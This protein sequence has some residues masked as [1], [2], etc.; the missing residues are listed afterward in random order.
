MAQD[1]RS[2]LAALKES[3]DLGRITREVDPRFEVA[4]LMRRGAEQ[5]AP[6]LY[7][8]HLRGKS[9]P[10]VANVLA[11]RRRLARALAT[12]AD[13]LGRAYRA[14]LERPIAA[15]RV[16]GWA[17]PMRLASLEQLP[18]ITANE[19]D[20]GPYITAGVVFSEH[21][22]SGRLNLSFQRM[23]PIS[24]DEIAIYV[25]ETSGLAEHG[26]AN[27]GR[28]L[29]V[30]V[31]IGLH[32]AF[33]FVA[34]SWYPPEMDEIAL[35]GGLLGEGVRLTQDRLGR[36][37]VPEAAEIVLEGEIDFARTVPEGPFGEYPG[38]Y[39]AGTLK[40]RP[41]PVLK[42]HR[43]SARGNP[44]YQTVI[45]G[46]TMS[47]ESCYF[48]CLSKESMLFTVLS[49][50][51]PQV[52]K[53]NVLLSR[54]IAVVQIQGDIDDAEAHRLLEAVFVNM[55]YIKFAILIDSDVDPADALDVLWALSTRVDPTRQMHV[56][57][58]MPM[59]PLDPSTNGRCD[60][61]GFDARKPTGAEQEG[62]VRTR[63]PGFEHMRLEDYLTRG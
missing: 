56:F 3:N 19:R 31:A 25:G 60:K 44:I 61:V 57:R 59:E 29:P 22:T 11:S 48:S 2:F 14:G 35:A 13:Q 6:A 20:A 21:P 12:T 63:I 18:I 42:L 26:Q 46:P 50:M 16:P 54:Y 58:D 43:M 17:H 52:V 7:F 45:T 5:D 24:D 15:V 8:E 40:P 30:T 34:A 28:P 55:I 33:M 37:T 62:F 36:W 10:L 9:I 49:R 4:A 27:G 23:C 51:C 47:Y 53:V 39:G 41:S 38:Y 32:P 1:L